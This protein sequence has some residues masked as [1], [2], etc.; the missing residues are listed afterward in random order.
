MS[1]HYIKVSREQI[2]NFLKYDHDLNDYCANADDRNFIVKT[3]NKLHKTISNLPLKIGSNVYGTIY[4]GEY[5][6]SWE[7]L[8]QPKSNNVLLVIEYEDDIENR[9]INKYHEEKLI[10]YIEG[11]IILGFDKRFIPD[12]EYEPEKFFELENKGND[13]WTDSSR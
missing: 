6:F 10:K 12:Y 3:S 5:D 4:I 9:R 2:L 1:N 11:F 7:L 8:N 13:G